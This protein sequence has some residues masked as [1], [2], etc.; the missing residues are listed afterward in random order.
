MK[1]IS[2]HE[3]IQE[4][5]AAAGIDLSYNPEE[6]SRRMSHLQQSA[7]CSYVVDDEGKAEVYY[8]YVADIKLLNKF[9]PFISVMSDTPFALAVIKDG[10]INI[11]PFFITKTKVSRGIITDLQKLNDTVFAH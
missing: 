1:I 10:E 9:E 5:V 7:G 3:T 4:A 2:T 8:V 11:G 6:A